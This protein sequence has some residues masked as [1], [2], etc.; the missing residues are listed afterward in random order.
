[1]RTASSELKIS[2][3]I[4]DVVS[5]LLKAGELLRIHDRHYGWSAGVCISLK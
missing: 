3:Y 5:V 2:L 1:M 4:S